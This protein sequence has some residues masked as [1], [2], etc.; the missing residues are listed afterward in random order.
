MGDDSQVT[1]PQNQPASEPSAAYPAELLRALMNERGWSQSDLAYVLGLKDPSAIT[2]ILSGKRGLSA[3]MVKLLATAFDTPA[4]VFSR[5]QAAYELRQAP[6][7]E[8]GVIA[9]ARIQTEYPLREMMKRG[10]FKKDATPAELEA[11]LRSFFEVKSLVDVPR[12]PHA[13]SRTGY[14]D[15]PASQ[16][17]WLFRVRQLAREMPTPIY[18]RE[19]L[20]K[21]LESMR[22]M[23]SDPDETRRIPRML[24]DCGVRYVVVEHLP[25]SKIDGVC[26]WLDKQSPVIG[27]SLRF[28]RIDNFWFVLRHE[29][30][31]V[32]HGHGQAVAIVDSDM[33]Q[34]KQNVTAEEQIANSEAAEFCVPSES[35]KSF[36]LR[37][38]PFFSESDVLA[39]SKRMKVHP[40]LAV[41]QLQRVANRY[42][43]LRKHLVKVRHHLAGSMMM[44]GWGDVVPV[45]I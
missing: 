39:F 43:I 38:N 42:D 4:E 17:A 27:M 31:H 34:P 26:L 22:G 21:A 5:A 20:Q 32:L 7:P 8:P 11:Q 25:G 35:I 30:S 6:D 2:Q 13:A 14:D 29:C 44:D 23:L 18:S 10:W 16:L 19:A 1:D 3:V 33:E 36:Y 12:L 24:H 45:E 15:I 41:G 28:D 40:G 37:K 9:R